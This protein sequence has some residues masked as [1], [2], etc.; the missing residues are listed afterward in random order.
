MTVHRDK[1]LIIKPTRC[2]DFSNL[3]WNETL[4]VSDSSSV[5]HQGGFHCTHSNGIRHTSLRTACK[6]DQ[7]V[8]SW[9]FLQAVSKL[10][11]RI[12][13]LCVQW[14]P[15]WWWTEE[16]SETCRVS[17]QNKFEKFV[18][19]V[20]FIIRS[21]EKVG[22]M[23]HKNDNFHHH[24]PSE[25]QTSRRCKCAVEKVNQKEAYWDY[26]THRLHYTH[27]KHKILQRFLG[28]ILLSIPQNS[29]TTFHIKIVYALLQE[30]IYTVILN[31]P[32]TMLLSE[33]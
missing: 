3:F 12:P 9:S 11:W 16:L 1:F 13:L 23:S 21:F 15:P 24:L 18:H 22:V 7:D 32:W 27:C 30:K 29:S 33:I 8:P 4:H 25:P 26:L 17:F 28:R 20:G 19:L 10:V 2:T 6:Q 14:K 5:H 31:Y